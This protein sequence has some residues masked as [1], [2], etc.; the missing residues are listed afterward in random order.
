MSPEYWGLLDGGAPPVP[1]IASVVTWNSTTDGSSMSSPAFTRVIGER[2][3]ASIGTAISP[4]TP[5]APTSITQTGLI[6]SLVD[7]VTRGQIN[8]SLWTAVAS[9][10]GSSALT[11]SYS[12]SMGSFTGNVVEAQNVNTI[13]Q[14]AVN[15]GS[16][17]SGIFIDAP[18]AAL[19]PTSAVLLV[20]LR[21]SSSG[22]LTARAGYSAIDGITVS[23]PGQNLRVTQ[24]NPGVLPAGFSQSAGGIDYE[25]VALELAS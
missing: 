7:Q 6:W 18:L 17:G 12:A 4:G 3:F 19:Q 16:P 13:V 24:A 23:T 8:L 1:L 11:A 25:M 5:L 9:S 10:S 2:Y 20:G 15:Q 14:S 22:S 21:N